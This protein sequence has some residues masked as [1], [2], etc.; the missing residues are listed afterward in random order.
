MN[1]YK[2]RFFLIVLTIIAVTFGMQSCSDEGTD[3]SKV[4]GGIQLIAPDNTIL[5][6]GDE[7]QLAAEVFPVSAADKSV[8]WKSDNTSV[9]TVDAGS[10]LVKAVSEGKA[11]ISVAS[12]EKSEVTK[13]CEVT[14]LKS[15]VV[16]FNELDLNAL[17]RIPTGA[18]RTLRATVSPA[19]I[20]QEVVWSSSNENVVTVE[21]GEITAIGAGTATVTAASVVNEDQKVEC[22]VSVVA[23]S[24]PMHEWL[25]GLWAFDDESNSCKATLGHDLERQERGFFPVE[26]DYAFADGPTAGDKA[27]IVPHNHY[28]IC[29]HGIVPAGGTT[30]S[31]DPAVRVN[32][33]SLLVDFMVTYIGHYY[34]FLQ[35]NLA[36]NDDGEYFINRTGLIGI[37]GYRT[38]VSVELNKW[39][40]CIITFK[41][42]E[43]WRVYLDG[44]LLFDA[45][46]VNDGKMGMDGLFSLD[47]AGTLLFGDENGEDNDLHVAAAAFYSK[48]LSAEEVVS[49]G[50]TSN[51]P[52]K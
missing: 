11:N 35:T 41:G 6:I 21:N 52:M 20:T 51:T 38:S 39:H 49:L 7:L 29:N 4:V 18:V 24:L 45:A 48:A 9:A 25:S 37:S 36:N 1:M 13:S 46:P 30:A 5:L 44:V 47:A 42:G 50:L 28:Y 3:W 15:L 10:G 19:S 23:S 31:G 17:Y 40:R 14:V 16:S 33:Y 43:Q 8:E 27:V 2:N 34:S 12:K 32:E 22:T 26:N